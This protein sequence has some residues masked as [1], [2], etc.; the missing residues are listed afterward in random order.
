L[1]D[2]GWGDDGALGDE[3][4][5]RKAGKGGAL[6]QSEIFQNMLDRHRTEARMDCASI[7]KGV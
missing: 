3:L 7:L 1:T 6:L 5:A 4:A 2:S